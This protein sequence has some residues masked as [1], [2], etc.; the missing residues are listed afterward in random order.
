MT[1]TQRPMLPAVGGTRQVPAPDQIAIDYILLGLRL[2][3]HLPGLVDGYF[4]PADLKARVDIEQRCPPRRLL[5][6]AVSLADRVQREVED[7]D[8]RDWLG[9]QLVALEAHAR[10]LAGEPL[11]YVE[12]VERCMGFA[13][14][15]H[16][17]ERFHAAAEALD[18][19]L[20]GA[21]PLHERLAA[22]DTSLEIPTEHLA[23]VAAWLVDRFRAR[24]VAAFGVPDGEA[25]TITLVKDQPW[26]AYNWYDGGRRSRIDIN[27]DLPAQAP[28]LILTVAHE[29]YPGHHLE[30]ATKEA[31]LVDRLGRMEAS[32]L[33]INTP[34]CPVSEGLAD[35]GTRLASPIDERADLLV[36]VMGRAG[37]PQ[38]ADRTAAQET[39]ERAV[40]L[41][42]P[43]RVLRAIAGNAALRRHADGRSSEDVLAYL[44]D[45]G[46]F[47]AEVAAK[48][49]EFIEHPL[50]KTYGFAYDQGESL[51]ARWVE[52]AEAPDQVGR[53]GIL[54]REQVTP[55]RLLAATG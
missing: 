41:S 10:T 26:G 51:V 55:R 36:E 39:A 12:Y 11:P 40:A 17:D 27:T 21:G 15:R 34:E 45:V 54:L 50:W 47:P 42:E 2:D 20:P 4:G 24:A 25:L 52:T 32:L 16:D 28:N 53:F 46:R 44:V 37:L 35:Y 8:R 31:E 14:I 9:G 49:L 30:H 23:A 38:S 18:G 22:W 6:D 43:R 48:R 3:Q 19:L 13:P 7:A 33:L 29:A 5:D 1:A